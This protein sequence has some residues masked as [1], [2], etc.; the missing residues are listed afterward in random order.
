M[1][2]SSHAKDEVM[3]TLT[4]GTQEQ[5]TNDKDFTEK[6]YEQGERKE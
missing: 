1:P 4:T 5:M 2:S 3:V 6:K